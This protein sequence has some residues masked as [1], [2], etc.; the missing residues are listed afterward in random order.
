[1]EFQPQYPCSIARSDLV[2]DTIPIGLIFPKDWPYR[3][4]FDYHLNEMRISG[5][6]ERLKRKYTRRNERCREEN[7]MPAGLSDVVCICII[8]ILGL[9]SASLLFLLES[10]KA[11]RPKQLLSFPSALQKVPNS[12][13]F[14]S[15]SLLYIQWEWAKKDQHGR[16]RI[17]SPLPTDSS[18]NL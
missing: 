2:L 9:V 18:A 6:L 13:I 14:W 7:V 3:E 15:R 17:C 5:V 10:C 16:I 1:M 4:L 12:E 8:P 11:R